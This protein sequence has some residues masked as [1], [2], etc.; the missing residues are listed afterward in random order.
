M[1]SSSTSRRVS[2]WISR[3]VSSRCSGE[4]DIWRR[5]L[6]VTSKVLDVMH[7]EAPRE[8]LVA[9]LLNLY[10]ELM[11]SR[12][13]SSSWTMRCCIA[14]KMPM[15]RRPRLKSLDRQVDDER[16]QGS[17]IRVRCFRW[18]KGRC[19]PGQIGQ[20]VAVRDHLTRPCGRYSERIVWP[21]PQRD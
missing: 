13:R 16:A 4:E 5:S 10:F 21:R 8:L 14:H 19:C 20:K 18:Q 1:G 7:A 2:I 17:Q 9:I 3:V 15:C 12:L 6:V 11:G